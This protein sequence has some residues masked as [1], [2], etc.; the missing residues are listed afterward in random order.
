MSDPAE[1]ELLERFRPYLRLLAR[2]QIGPRLQ[3]K[4]DASD[5]VQQTLLEAYRS[6]DRRT[7]G[8]EAQVAAWL[9]AILARQAAHLVRDLGRDRRD[10]RREQSLEQTLAESSACLGRWLAAD[11]P[12]PS[13][14]AGRRERAVR[15]AAALEQLPEAQREAVVLHYWQGLSLAEIGS[16]L[17]RS[18][19]AVAGLLQRGLRELRRRLAGEEQP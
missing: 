6:R 4:A 7:A 2:L 11:G 17:D 8:S 18:V 10:V 9:R 12:S 13:D 16:R 19:S 1:G 5:L 14:E 3:G 15:V